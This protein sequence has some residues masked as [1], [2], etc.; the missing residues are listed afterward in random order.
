MKYSQMRESFLGSGRQRPME[1]KSVDL[2]LYKTSW[3]QQDL[4]FQDFIHKILV[5]FCAQ[6]QFTTRYNEHKI[7]FFNA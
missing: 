2:D 1:F 4:N 3:R 6:I 7:Y 5:K